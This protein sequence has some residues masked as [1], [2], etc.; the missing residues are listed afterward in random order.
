MPR[1][2]AFFAVLSAGLGVLVLKAP[3]MRLAAQ[4]ASGQI[5]G[6][7][8]PLT[9]FVPARF[10][11]ECVSVRLGELVFQVP[12]HAG[13]KRA[14]S[15]E[16]FG[17]LLTFDGLKCRVL[18]PRYNTEEEGT[19]SWSLS[20]T[21]GRD[22]LSRQAAVCAASGADL[23]FGL[24]RAEVQRLR[25]RLEIRPALCLTAERVEV[26]RGE[27][28]CGLLLTWKVEGV[29]RMVFTYFSPDYRVSGKVFLFP[30]SDSADAAQAA[31]ALVSTFRLEGRPIARAAAK[32]D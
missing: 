28:L 22:E 14:A 18:P 4:I 8:I 11:Q 5:D 19:A 25:E 27:T 7:R 1:P 15:D 29:P 30:D 12:R 9:E 3:H 2:I 21:G 17:F 16:S 32:P 6:H 24:S 13:I 31:Q 26:V 23:S 10:P 20:E